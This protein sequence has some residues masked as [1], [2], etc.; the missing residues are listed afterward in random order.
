MDSIEDRLPDPIAPRQRGP[1]LWPLVLLVLVVGGY[2]VNVWFLRDSTGQDR[3]METGATAILSIF[4]LVI[5]LALFSRLSWRFRISGLVLI[6]ALVA[7]AAFTLDID[8]VTGDL[9]P[10]P[11]FRWTEEPGDRLEH[12]DKMSIAHSVAPTPADYPGFLGANRD[13]R[14]P[15]AQLSRDWTT[16]PPRELW[17]RPVG[18][19]YSAFAVVG[20]L[21]VTQEQR[22]PQEMVVAYDLR[23]GNEIWRHGDTER[24][25]NPAGGVGPR[26]TPTVDRDLVYALG[27]EGLLNCLDL[28][29]GKRIWFRKV[30]EDC[31]RASLPWGCSSSP[32][33]WGDHVI[34]ASGQIPL[35]DSDD[36]SSTEE[37]SEDPTPAVTLSSSSAT[38]I[39]YQRETGEIVWRSGWDSAGYSSPQVRTLCGVDQ[40]LLFNQT[41]ASA[42]DPSSG[43]ILWEHPWSANQPNV[44]QPLPLGDDE[45]LISSGYGIGSKALEIEKTGDR[46]SATVRWETPRLKAK[47]T[48][49][50]LHEGF[51]YGLDDGTLTCLDPREGQRKWKRGRYGHGQVL[52][53][54]DLLLLQAESGALVLLEPNPEAH[55][56]LATVEVLSGKTWNHPVLCGSILLVRNHVEAACYELPMDP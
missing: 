15:E 18:A 47:F 27:A 28:A 25:E 41:S 44:C 46:Y 2:L 53:A 24:Y 7:G 22:G 29:T 4:F 32:L 16:Q 10:I 45:L 34:V 37:G 54:G 26:A 48:N 11:K 9:V 3:A 30:L 31:A 6:F 1:R 35:F 20:D 49:L 55:V 19:S 52:L 40:L 39:A 50:V 56:E 23:N 36:E 17:R 13:A 38:V 8:T 14:I 42:H 5:W 21:A 51:V 33:V 43:T 12:T